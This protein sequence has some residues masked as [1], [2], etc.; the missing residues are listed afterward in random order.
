[1]YNEAC[2]IQNASTRSKL[3]DL[4]VRYPT[5]YVNNKGMQPPGAEGD[6]D[7]DVSKLPKCFYVNTMTGSSQ[8]T[9]PYYANSFPAVDVE[10]TSFE[11]CIMNRDIL[12]RW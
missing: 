12:E 6:D 4:W 7:V 11:K 8:W 10:A 1:M 5:R 2:I 9:V 3:E